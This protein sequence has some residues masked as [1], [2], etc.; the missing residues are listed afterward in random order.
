MAAFAER[1]WGSP[2][3]YEDF[4]TRLS[5]HLRYLRALGVAY[6]TPSRADLEP[7][8]PATC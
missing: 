7:A 5:P 1:A 4:L 3:T 2:S 8:L 6:R